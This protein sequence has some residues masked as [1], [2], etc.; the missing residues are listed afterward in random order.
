MR[1]PRSARS[2]CLLSNGK[3]QTN[4]SIFI[5]THS[6]CLNGLR[7]ERTQSGEQK[8]SRPLCG[9]ATELFRFVDPDRNSDQLAWV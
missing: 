5:E 3:I 1:G 7:H 6:I 2:Q 4:H 8:G 9:F